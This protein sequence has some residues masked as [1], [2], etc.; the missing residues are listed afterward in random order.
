[1][2]YVSSFAAFVL[3]FGL[4]SSAWGDEPAPGTEQAPLERTTDKTVERAIGY[5]QAESASW[6]K[7]R[8]CAACHHVPLALWALNEAE[9]RGYAIDK[10]YVSGTIEALLGDKDKLMASRIFPNPAAPPDPRPQGRG[11][12]MGLP[13]LSLA[14]RSAP[15]LEIGQRESLNLIAEEIVSK[16]QPDGSWEFFAGLRRPPINETQ[17]TDVAWIIMALQAEL[18]PS[19]PETRRAAFDKAVAWFDSVTK[20]S[21]TKGSA[22]KGA[23]DVAPAEEPHQEKIMKALLGIRLG[24]PRETYQPI[25]DE[26]LASQG[27]DGGWRQNVPDWPSD[28]FATGQT[29]YLL[30]QAGATAETPE[31]KR[32]I[33]FLL[34]TQIADGSWPMLSRSTPDGSPGSSKLLTPINCGACSWATLGLVSL[35]PKSPAS[36]ASPAR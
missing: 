28:A 16:Q 18:E 32:G 22:T 2:R 20:G 25:L 26:L 23:Q 27:A 10:P 30:S 3:A 15:S 8:G 11:L 29:L 24:R 21:A 19:A 36:A 9:R 33:D 12:N 5:L 13:M 6:L 14:A 17:L 1:M 35:I 31:I 4:T 34:A 7:S